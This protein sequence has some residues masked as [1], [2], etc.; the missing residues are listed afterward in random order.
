LPN[1]LGVTIIS[2]MYSTDRAELAA[3]ALAL[4]ARNLRAAAEQARAWFPG[5]STA[6]LRILA[7]DANEAAGALDR[8]AAALPEGDDA[9][10]LARDQA[11]AIRGRWVELIDDA[12]IDQWGKGWEI[13]AECADGEEGAPRLRFTWPIM[14]AL[15]AAAQVAA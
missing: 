11:E 10:E 2:G 9:R 3:A 13:Y 14:A 8:L 6:T 1:I 12:H 15:V 5:V 7:D 4:Y